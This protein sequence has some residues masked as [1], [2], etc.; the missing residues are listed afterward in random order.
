MV[1]F[2]CGDIQSF[3]CVQWSC[4]KACDFQSRYNSQ[5]RHQHRAFS[6]SGC[7]DAGKQWLRHLH[8]PQLSSFQSSNLNLLSNPDIL[9]PKQFTQLPI[10]MPIAFNNYWGLPL[11][12]NTKLEYLFETL[13]LQKKTT[14]YAYW[15]STL[16]SISIRYQTKINKSELYLRNLDLKF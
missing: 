16:H 7:K 5:H 6:S 15:S 10:L 3:G 4:K 12:S 2:L 13:H 1:F 8:V 14:K 9:F 11:P